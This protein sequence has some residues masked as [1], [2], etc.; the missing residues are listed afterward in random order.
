MRA[1]RKDMSIKESLLLFL[2]GIITCLKSE[3]DKAALCL[4]KRGSWSPT[5]E[6][7]AT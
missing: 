3:Y 6:R 7:R 2:R 1:G 5:L 4:P